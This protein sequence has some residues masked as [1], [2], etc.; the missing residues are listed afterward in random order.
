MLVYALILIWAF[1]FAPTTWKRRA[2][3]GSALLIPVVILASSLRITGVTGDLLPIFEPRWKKRSAKT[4]SRTQQTAPSTNAF[5]VRDYPQYLGP[6]RDSSVAI[7]LATNWSAQ[8][9]KEL[10]RRSVGS[11]W[12]GFSVV[13]NR[14]VTHEQQGDQEVVTCYQL[15][16]GAPIWKHGYSARYF[17]TI[18][19][20]GPRA[21]P[22][23]S[24]N[25]VYAFGGTGILTCVDLESGKALWSHD[26]L[27]EH[28]GS[29][30]EWGMASAPLV[31]GE[32]VIVS[33]SGG[34]SLVAYKRDSGE[35]AWIGGTS[36]GGYSWP[37]SATLLGEEVILNFNGRSASAYNP[38][39]GAELWSHPWPLSYPNV[40]AP[41]PL[42]SNLV[43]LTTGYGRGSE[44]L[45]IS[46]SDT[47]WTAKSL[48]KSN[49]LK[50]KFS[51]ILHIGDYIYGLDDGI[52][53]CI[54]ASDG[55]LQWKE[56]RFGH[57]QLILANNHILLVTESGEMKLLQ[58]HPQRLI[59]LASMKVFSD[60]TWNP[61]TLAGQIY[62][63]RND[64]EA[65]CYLM[66]LADSQT[67]ATR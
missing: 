21:T 13:G 65:A 51:N 15:L 16:T 40:T 42:A 43:F 57:C 33:A 55:S 6:N 56:G 59:E 23:I 28:G 20:E 1:L 5:V 14:A 25:R 67:I 34:K 64:R 66:P 62:L 18:A 53:A 35:L 26:V 29:V 24:S 38:N 4:A 7:G 49:R 3:L 60:K 63:A 39:S 32:H 58:P 47:N 12:S 46:R 36:S 17:T 48:Y 61:S 31:T 44:L 9:P 30:P 54:K 10:W 45:Q 41:L 52:M 8:P 27:K 2:L 37:V 19:G 11:A 50:S 22:T